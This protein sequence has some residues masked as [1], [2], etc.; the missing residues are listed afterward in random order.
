MTP[1]RRIVVGT[2]GSALADPTVAR[3]AVLAASEGA[4][5]VIVCAYSGVTQ[6]DEARVGGLGDTRVGTVLGRAAAEDAVAAAAA[7]ASGLGATVAAPLL[8]ESDPAEALV[9]A[10]ASRS[11]DLVVIGAIRDV[12]IADRLLGTVASAVVRRAACEVLVV[13]PPKSWGGVEDLEVPADA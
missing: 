11:A 6:R 3:A 12:S 2:D 13:R 9:A 4:E 10:A 5:L 1:Y 8:V 7:T